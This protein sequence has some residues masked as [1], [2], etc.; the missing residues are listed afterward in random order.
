MGSIRRHV[1]KLGLK[2]R[3]VIAG[4]FNAGEGSAP[5]RA[6]IDHDPTLP[7]L[8]DTYRAAHP[9]RVDGEGTFSAWSGRRSGS[10]IDWVL[11]TSHFRTHSANIDRFNVSGRYPSDHYPVT[12]VLFPR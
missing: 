2:A 1:A 7:A 10:R 11:H 6:L 8:V 3:V 5:Y 4:D 12:A 9:A